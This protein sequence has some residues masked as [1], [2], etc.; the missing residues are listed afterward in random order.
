MCIYVGSTHSIEYVG[1]WFRF[2]SLPHVYCVAQD[3]D[4]IDG[5]SDDG[6]PDKGQYFCH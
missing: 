6:S 5:S 4:Q 3:G 1:I 2:V